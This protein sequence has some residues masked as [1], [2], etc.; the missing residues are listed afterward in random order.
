VVHSDITEEKVDAIV[1]CTNEYMGHIDIFNVPNDVYKVGGKTIWS[2]SQDWINYN[3]P[4]KFIGDIGV[5]SGGKMPC[6][7]VLH[8]L[9]DLYSYYDHLKH[10]EQL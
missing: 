4:L 7:F 5:T 8:V 3:K 2:E 9:T 10:V 1:N 6:K